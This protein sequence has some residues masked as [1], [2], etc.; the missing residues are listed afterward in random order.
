MYPVWAMMCNPV[1][2]PLNLLDSEVTETGHVFRLCLKFETLH[3]DPH[4]QTW[5]RIPNAAP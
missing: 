2:R 5:S 3:A 4:T 1:S